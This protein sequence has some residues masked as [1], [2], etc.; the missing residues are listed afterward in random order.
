MQATL[1]MIAALLIS[2]KCAAAARQITVAS[3][4]SPLEREWVSDCTPVGL[5][6]RHGQIVRLV[7]TPSGIAATGQLYAHNSCDAPTIRSE[8]WGLI[9]RVSSSAARW[10][11]DY[12]LSDV[13]FTI[14]SDEVTAVYN[15]SAG[16]GLTDWRINIPRSVAG[17]HCAP[18]DIPP[19]GQMLFESAWIAGE[20]LRLGAFP[21]LSTN[22]SA[23]MRPAD[24][25]P[26]VFH[27]EGPE[28]IQ[29]AAARKP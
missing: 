26:V 19:H 9:R 27:R 3:S 6:G 13:T 5:N 10:E 4:A 23:E 12:E 18:F 15:K 1:A 21:V 28:N 25:G 20:Q 17:R 24:P 2:A 22:R 14:L 8:Y 11:L 29:G 16:C 7:I